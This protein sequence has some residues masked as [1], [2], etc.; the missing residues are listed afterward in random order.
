M[1]IYSTGET[2]IR[3]FFLGRHGDKDKDGNLTPLGHTQSNA[4]GVVLSQKNL[5]PFGWRVHSPVPRCR[6]TLLGISAV[7][8]LEGVPMAQCD[9]LLDSELLHKAELREW[10]IDLYKKLGEVPLAKFRESDADRQAM[11]E[12]GHFIR[13]AL[14]TN[15]MWGNHGNFIGIG[16]GVYLNQGI[17]S[18]F[19]HQMPEEGLQEILEGACLAVATGYLIGVDASWAPVHMERLSWEED[20]VD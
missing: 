1:L 11:D 20:Q 17:L 19:G 12:L 18:T 16:H 3:F 2:P 6:D 5:G 15:A 9:A 14:N 7:L 4:L 13:I 8:G 10:R